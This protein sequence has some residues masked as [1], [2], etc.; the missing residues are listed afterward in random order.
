MKHLIMFIGLL[1]L[2]GCQT[3]EGIDFEAKDSSCT[4]T[5]RNRY[6]SCMGAITMMPIRKNN[7]CVDNLRFCVAQCPS[8]GMVVV[9]VSEN[10]LSSSTKKLE[11]LNDM[12]KKGLI[13][14]DEYN[15]KKAEILRGM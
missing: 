10:T 14:R 1:V 8:K 6:D 9:P 7:D 12:Q 5:C 15:A 3:T 13:T 2:V 4:T 11:I